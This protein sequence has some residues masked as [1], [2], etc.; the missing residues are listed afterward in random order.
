MNEYDSR[1]WCRVRSRTFYR[2]HHVPRFQNVGARRTWAGE[3]NVDLK[4]TNSKIARKT[5]SREGLTACR[6]AGK[7]KQHVSS[8]TKTNEIQDF[9]SLVQRDRLSSTDSTRGYLPRSIEIRKIF[10]HM[11]SPEQLV[12]PPLPAIDSPF[13]AGRQVHRCLK[14]TL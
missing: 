3:V 6:S 7:R 8:R 5:P 14:H 2:I 1:S 11:I 10:T 12:E 4:T 9:P 13:L